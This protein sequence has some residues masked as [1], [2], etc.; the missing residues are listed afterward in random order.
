MH[1]VIYSTTSILVNFGCGRTELVEPEKERIIYK[2][3][4]RIY[5]KYVIKG[6][7]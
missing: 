1:V 2:G 5:S 6:N 7:L 4:F 3:Y